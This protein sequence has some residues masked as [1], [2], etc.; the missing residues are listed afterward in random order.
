M[1]I[2]VLNYEFPP[3]GG[4]ASPVSKELAE[5][6][7]ALGHHVEVVTMHY[8][9]LKKKE[10]INKV[11]IHRVPCL[12]SKMNIC[13][14]H[15]QLSYLYN[16]RKF[17]NK[18]LQNN[19]FDVCHCHFLI[20]TGVLT[21]WLKRKFNIPSFITIHGSDIPGFN[22]NRF[23]LLH[24]FTPLLIRR[25]AQ[26]AI[27]V[28]SPSF[29]LKELYFKKIGVDH[30]LV[31][32]N[33][34]EKVEG[35][36]MLSKKNIIL[37]TGRL[38]KRKGFLTLVAAACE[39]DQ[40]FDLHICGDGPIMDEL[41]KISQNSKMKISFHGWIDN[42]SALYQNLL[43]EAKIYVLVSSHENASIS[44]LEAMSRGCAVI[45][46]NT[47]GCLEMANDVGICIPPHDVEQ[48]KAA[49]IKVIE[50]DEIRAEMGEK[51]LAKCRKEYSWDS[52]VQSYLEIMENHIHSLRN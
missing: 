30:G 28:V 10:V 22:P 18:Y 44:I 20:P 47:T 7:V 46:S 27:Q 43:K 16:A 13:H 14:P 11:I 38:L 26:N 5:R 3:L 40:N 2:L 39:L 37:S 33:G 6:M 12:R 19:A 1:R 45:T 49:L 9:T 4:G 41:K 25:I 35:N 34:I 15:E 32:P 31:I 24:K 42:T 17:L 52:I 8:H 50:N 21:L 51:A 48:M 29:Y 36:P 23:Q